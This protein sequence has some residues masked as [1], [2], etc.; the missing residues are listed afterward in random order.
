MLLDVESKVFSPA[1]LRTVRLLL[2]ALLFEQKGTG[3]EKSMMRLFCIMFWKVIPY[4]IIK[5][6]L[7]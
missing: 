4:T 2:S 3:I 1:D 6:L 7:R 5:C